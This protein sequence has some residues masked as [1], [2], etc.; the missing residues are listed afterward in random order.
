[1]RELRN[2]VER[3]VLF[4]K[5]DTI[6]VEHLPASLRKKAPGRPVAAP[7]AAEVVT[8]LQ[9]AVKQAE[10]SAIRAALAKTEGK[11]SDAAELLGVSR[12]TL[13]EKI[14]NYGLAD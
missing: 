4:C 12:K 14:R 6:Q 1:M 7:P 11:R 9:D 10:I 2:V 13:W 8:N 3:S 5:G